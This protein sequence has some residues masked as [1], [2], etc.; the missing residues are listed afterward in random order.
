LAY[1]NRAGK[2]ENDMNTCL[3]PVQLLQFIMIG[4]GVVAFLAS[5]IIQLLQRQ[6]KLAPLFF[7]LGM[8]L[9][10]TS[11]F[12]GVLSSSDFSETSVL[13]NFPCIQMPELSMQLSLFNVASWLC[14]GF[15]IALYLRTR[16]D[17]KARAMIAMDAPREESGSSTQSN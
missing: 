12:Q 10:S 7:A 11:M 15:G 9:A 5:A 17:Q 3:E 2:G 14:F 4:V 8:P 13:S 1:S 6:L 16:T